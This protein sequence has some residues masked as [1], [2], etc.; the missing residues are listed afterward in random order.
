MKEFSEEDKQKIIEQQRH[1]CL[2][3]GNI[4]HLTIHHFKPKSLGGSGNIL[5]GV[6]LCRGK[7]TNN[8]HTKADELT[9]NYGIPFKRIAEEG[10]APLLD[11]LPRHQVIWRRHRRRR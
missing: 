2:N 6:G 1:K 5:N 9:I 8:C 11:S 3:C 7:G 4:G 10:I